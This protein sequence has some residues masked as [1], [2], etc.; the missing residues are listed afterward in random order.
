MTNII[1]TVD[2][3][4]YERD[5]TETPAQHTGVLVGWQGKWVKLD[6]SHAHFTEFDEQ[7][8][9]LLKIGEKAEQTSGGVVARK[10]RKQ[11][12]RRNRAY[13]AGL[14]EY[15]DRNRISKKDGTGRPAYA[16]N[17][18]RNDYPDWLIKMYDEHLAKQERQASPA[19]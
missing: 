4:D 1:K 12:N 13:Y 7:L 8:G 2:T 14:V 11:N 5:E 16:G 15:A 19:A 3:I 9:H 6:M 17:N 10:P 18:G